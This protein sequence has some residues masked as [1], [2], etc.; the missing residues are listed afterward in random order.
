MASIL[1]SFVKAGIVN[2]KFETLVALIFFQIC[3]GGFSDDTYATHDCLLQFLMTSPDMARRFLNSTR[4]S[5]VLYLLHL[6]KQCLYY[7]T[8]REHYSFHHG[9]YL[10]F[11]VGGVV[12]LH[13]S[14]ITCACDTV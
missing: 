10:V 7:F 13:D 11:G 14:S 2:C 6:L 9:L 4:F 12:G 3:E 1:S 8:T 5:M